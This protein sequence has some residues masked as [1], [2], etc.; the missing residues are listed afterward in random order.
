MLNIL[1]VKELL[2]QAYWV[3]AKLL[4]QLFAMKSINVSSI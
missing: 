1:A 4:I 2:I 3:R